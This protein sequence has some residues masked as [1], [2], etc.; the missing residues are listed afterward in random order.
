MVL[1]VC[2]YQNVLCLCHFSNRNLQAAKEE[3]IRIDHE[4]IYVTFGGE[5]QEGEFDQYDINDHKWYYVAV[6]WNGDTGRVEI[7]VNSIEITTFDF[8]AYAGEE[9][10]S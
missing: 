10:P 6:L 7:R 1:V 3:I 2:S 8:S 4:K 5:S 9:L